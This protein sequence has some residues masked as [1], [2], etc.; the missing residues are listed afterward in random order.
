MFPTAH[1]GVLLNIPLKFFQ[2]N[3][4]NAV[5]CKPG[6]VLGPNHSRATSELSPPVTPSHAWP[7]ARRGPSQEAGVRATNGAGTR[8]PISTVTGAGCRSQAD[9][10]TP[11]FEQVLDARLRHLST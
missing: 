10:H 8:A 3:C 1:K 7:Q 6:W 2:N 5:K 11:E 4:T 9:L